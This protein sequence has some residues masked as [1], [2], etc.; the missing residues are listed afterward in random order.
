[1]PDYPRPDN[2]GDETGGLE[3]GLLELMTR[4]PAWWADAACREAPAD[5]CWFPE[6]AGPDAPSSAC[7][8]S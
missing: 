3:A 8:L 5:I 1:L 2:I 6:N 4:R 7:A